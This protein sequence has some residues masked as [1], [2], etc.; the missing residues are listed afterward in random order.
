VRSNPTACGR[1]YVR[2][3]HRSMY[4]VLSLVG[5]NSGGGQVLRLLETRF[6]CKFTFEFQRWK[7]T[8]LRIREEVLR[9][10]VI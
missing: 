2:V 3:K 5:Q 9:L 6:D 8:G 4:R 7:A 10:R 1:G